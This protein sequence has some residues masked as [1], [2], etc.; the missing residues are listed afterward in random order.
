MMREMGFIFY[1]YMSTNKIERKWWFYGIWSS[2][3]FL[4]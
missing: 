3:Y 4:L 2:R 1:K